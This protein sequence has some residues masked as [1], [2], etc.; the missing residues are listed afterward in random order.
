MIKFFFHGLLQ[1]SHNL[2]KCFMSLES[3]AYCQMEAAGILLLQKVI[4]MFGNQLIVAV[5]IGK[6]Q[7]RLSGI[8]IQIKKGPM[9]IFHKLLINAI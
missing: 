3:A 6:E 9:Q 7:H 5:H 1:L 8:Q 4:Q 2:R